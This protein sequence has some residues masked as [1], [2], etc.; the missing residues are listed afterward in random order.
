VRTVNTRMVVAYWLIGREIVQ[1]EQ[2]GKKRAGYGDAL[3]EDLSRRLTERYGKGYSVTNLKNFR[4]FH[5]A[6]AD[7]LPPIRQTSSDEF[8]GATAIRQALPHELADL[9]APACKSP[10]QFA[11][12]CMANPPLPEGPWGFAPELSWTHYCLL[13]RVENRSARSFY[14]IQAARERWSSRDLERQINSLLFERL[15]KSRNKKGVMALARKGSQPQKPVDILRGG[16]RNR[17]RWRCVRPAPR[18][19]TIR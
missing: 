6:Y 4:T 5:L 13:M 2:G 8:A 14:E 19:L 9:R 18:G 3:L 12:Q 10:P 15:L 17:R 11:G 16:P 7:R 1:E